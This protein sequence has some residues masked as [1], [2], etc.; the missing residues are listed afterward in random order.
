MKFY[1]GVR[2]GKGSKWLDLGDDLH[3][4]PYLDGVLSTASAWNMMTS[5]D[6]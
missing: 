3:H 1:G 6:I 2:D 4:N 5:V